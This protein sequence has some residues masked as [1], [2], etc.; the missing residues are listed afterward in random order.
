MNSPVAAV[1]STPTQQLDT[2]DADGKFDRL[3]ALAAE[4]VALKLD[5]IVAGSTI[6]ALAAQ[7]ATKTLPIVFVGADDPVGNGRAATHVDK[8]LKGAKPADLPVEQP[9]RF[10]LEINLKTAKDSGFTIPQ[11]VMARADELIQ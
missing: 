3:P 11:S 2:E 10:E 4:L 9:A 8:I 6:A 1:G 7:R 5:V